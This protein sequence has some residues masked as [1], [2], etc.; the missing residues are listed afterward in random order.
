MEKREENE[1]RIVRKWERKQEFGKKNESK[2]KCGG[3][4]SK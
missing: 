2:R 4:E 1:K 3:K